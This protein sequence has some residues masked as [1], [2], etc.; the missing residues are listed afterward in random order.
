MNVF[1]MSAK[2]L[3][4]FGELEKLAREAEEAAKLI[5][6]KFK[7]SFGIGNSKIHVFH[8]ESCGE[9]YG[10]GYLSINLRFH[11][12]DNW[13]GGREF[14]II[15]N[16]EGIYSL[17]RSCYLKENGLSEHD[18]DPVFTNIEHPDDRFRDFIRTLKE[19]E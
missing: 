12:V 14:S 5:A 1:S 11:F 16:Q 19:E 3:I 15:A 4:A 17:Y 6:E 18:P 8:T 13:W 9:Y 2:E 7:S 10:D